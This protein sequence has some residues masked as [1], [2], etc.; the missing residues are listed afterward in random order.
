M[1]SVKKATILISAFIVM[2]F[3]N[4]T[5]ALAVGE[6]LTQGAFRWYQN[7]DG[8]PMPEIGAPIAPQ[9]TSA[10]APVQGEGARLR[11]LMTV[12]D[13]DLE[14]GDASFKLQT[15]QRVGTCD[16]GFVGETYSD[17]GIGQP[18][19]TAFNY[20]STVATET[21]GINYW[22][23]VSEAST[24]NNNSAYY[25]GYSGQTFPSPYLKAT[26]FGFN[27]DSSYTI[28]G[29]EVQV[30]KNW[31]QNYD[32]NPVIDNAVRIIK[33]GAIGTADRSVPGP[34]PS[35]DTFIT[36]G[37]T[38]DLW[39]H[40]WTPSD[41]NNQNFGMAL[42]AG[43]TG[44]GY[45]PDAF[46]D[47]IRIKIYFAGPAEVAS[48]N[49][50]FYYD[51]DAI[52]STSNDPQIQYFSNKPQSYNEDANFTNDEYDIYDGEAGLWDFSIQDFSAN[53]ETAYCFR[54]VH[55]ND[56]LLDSYTVIPELHI[57]ANPPPERRLRGGNF[58]CVEQEKGRFIWN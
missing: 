8:Q 12:Q 35:I 57:C 17:F 28:T 6:Y 2:F 43:E 13:Q 50:S 42:S 1:G 38:S 40:S 14:I 56:T 55:A 47:S 21:Q 30:E 54:V 24:S 18:S 5:P 46:V 41:I 32:N 10:V 49:N 36:H 58:F 23:N 15:A 48:F 3:F 4:I 53:F 31:Q 22:I 44:G 33:G 52:L 7:V 51:D 11:L 20:P 27:I 37:G 9:N 34:W 25:S 19:S 26:N 16:T 45:P 29:I 39:G